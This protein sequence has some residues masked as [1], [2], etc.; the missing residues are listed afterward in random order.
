MA[1]AAPG[2]G[3]AAEPVPGLDSPQEE[4]ADELDDISVPS[5]VDGDKII[6]LQ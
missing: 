4:F 5:S 6:A 3:D 2:E 1:T